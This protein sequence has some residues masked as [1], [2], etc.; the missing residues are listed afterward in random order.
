[1][2]SIR[3]DVLLRARKM[4]PHSMA[5]RRTSKATNPI[6]RFDL[7]IHWGP[8]STALSLLPLKDKLR[9]RM[10]TQNMMWAPG[11]GHHLTTHMITVHHVNWEPSSVGHSLLSRCMFAQSFGCQRRSHQE[12][13]ATFTTQS[14]TQ[15]VGNLSLRRFIKKCC[16]H[17]CL[18]YMFFSLLLCIVLVL[19]P[20]VAAFGD[21]WLVVVCNAVSPLLCVA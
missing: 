10:T 21:H 9:T 5:P 13:Q 3:S 17:P 19:C 15:P 20:I 14:G 2:V 6:Q 7:G 4:M 12:T 11:K 1:M 16:Q 8:S 18:F